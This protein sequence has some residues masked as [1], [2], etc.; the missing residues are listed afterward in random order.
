MN[1]RLY[2]NFRGAMHT[3]NARPQQALTPVPGSLGLLPQIQ[4]PEEMLRH[5]GPSKGW[6][7]LV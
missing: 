5:R 3:S 1:N 2:E 4:L 7:V 6:S